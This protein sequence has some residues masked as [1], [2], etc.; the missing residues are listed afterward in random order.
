MHGMVYHV[1]RFMKKHGGIKKFTGQGKLLYFLLYIHQSTKFNQQS[2]KKES[3]TEK[4]FTAS[5]I[6]DW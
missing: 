1:P 4:K 3:F 5:N 6:T 2:E